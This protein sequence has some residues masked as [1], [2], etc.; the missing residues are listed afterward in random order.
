[1]HPLA[2]MVRAL[3]YKPKLPELA[4]SNRVASGS[5]A[6]STP[7]PG[8]ATIP[9]YITHFLNTYPFPDTYTALEWI[10]FKDISKQDMSLKELKSWFDANHLQIDFHVWLWRDKIECKLIPKVPKDKAWGDDDVEVK[11]SMDST[12]TLPS[13]T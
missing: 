11:G 4:T 6:D 3:G 12:A 9:A 1:M 13:M 2:Q 5:G 10:F 7:G 8:T